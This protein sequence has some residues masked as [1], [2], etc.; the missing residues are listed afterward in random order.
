MKTL[1]K[2]LHGT[3]MGTLEARLRAAF[4]AGIA[5]GMLQS[6]AHGSEAATVELTP[7]ADGPPP[8]VRVA[9]GEIATVTFTD[10]SGA[11]RRIAWIEG[12]GVAAETAPSHPHVAI[13]RAGDGRRGGSVVAL[14]EGVDQPVHLS[15]SPQAAASRLEVRVAVPDGAQPL[16]GTGGAGPAVQDRA[17]VESIV[18]EYLLAHPEIIEEATDPRHRLA[19]RASDLRAELLGDGEVPWAGVGADAAAV[20]VV[21]FFDYRCGYC[22]RS[23]DAVREVA[24]QPD[25]RVELRDYPILGADSVRASRLALAAGLQGSYADAHFALMAREDDYG[26]AA[27]SELASALGLDAERLRA[28]M[29]SAAVT[30]RIDANRALARRLGVTGTP[31]FLVVGA[32]EV[33]AA[34]GSLDASALSAMV[35][36]VR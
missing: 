14:L 34:P 22:K 4:A 16:E 18:R 12:A 35:D 29:D 25:V 15:A 1:D 7:E 24:A 28:D 20:T 13:L 33:R 8:A 26:D 23:T 5:L 2:P 21:E 19:A 36:E 32:E 31:A 30:A 27:T 11:P 10:R 6:A 9:S 3:P 17:A